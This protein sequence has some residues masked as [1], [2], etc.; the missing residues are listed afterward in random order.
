VAARHFAAIA[1]LPIECPSAFARQWF[2]RKL[3]RVVAVTEHTGKQP[4]EFLG[5]RLGEPAV[6]LFLP[7]IGNTERENV[8]A[9]RRGWILGKLFCP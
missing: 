1:P 3:A 6:Q 7:R 4:V 5:D 8:S 2:G 9:Q